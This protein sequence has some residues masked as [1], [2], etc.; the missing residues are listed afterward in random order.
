[1]C[2]RDGGI[3]QEKGRQ[4]GYMEPKGKQVALVHVHCEQPGIGD[5]A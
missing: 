2:V 5:I 3:A 1:M 4:G